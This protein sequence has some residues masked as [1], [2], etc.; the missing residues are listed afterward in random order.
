MTRPAAALA[1]ALSLAAGAAPRAARAFTVQVL[2][3]TELQVEPRLAPDRSSLALRVHLQDDRGRPIAGRAVALELRVDDVPRPP[4]ALALGPGGEA[5]HVVPVGRGDRVV[6]ARV[7]Y[8][9]D[10]RTAPQE[11]AVR[12]GLNVP[13]VTVDVVVPPGGVELGGP[14]APFVVTLHVGEVV[15]FSPHGAVVELREGERSLAEG[16][17]DA[18]GRAVLHVRPDVFREPRVYRV[19]AVTS[20][21][22]ERVEGPGRDL[23]VRA[24]TAVS[25]VRVGEPGDPSAPVA[26]E[27][28]LITLTRAP[29][30]DA[31]VR[32]LRGSVTVAGARTDAGGGFRVRLPA[33]L[34]AEPDVSVRASFE[35]TEPWYGASESPAV[36]LT[37]PAPRR[38]HWAWVVAPAALAAAAAALAAVRARRRGDASGEAPAVPPAAEGVVR[39]EHVRAGAAAGLRVRFEAVDRATARPVEDVCARWAGGEWVP[40]GEAVAVQPARRIEFEVGAP[41]YSPRKVTG[42]FARPGEYVVRVQLRTWREELFER[43]RPW[44]RKASGRAMPTLREALGARA[45]TPAAVSFVEHVEQ[46]CYAPDAPTARDVARAEE[47]AAALDTDVPP[48]RP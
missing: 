9:G 26:L 1:L 32:V 35:P 46:G 4:V 18:T 13:Y 38:V 20:V 8:E 33:E 41:G 22:G 7:R 27:G 23:L 15:D 12:V 19:R 21:D 16:F 31:P 48:L 10:A 11:R 45:A 34:L 25:L 24:R 42:E 43:A 29:V 6:E 3:A 30:A 14:P 5:T 28:A 39:V 17:A 37:G 2:A 47:L 40:A 44:L 36:A